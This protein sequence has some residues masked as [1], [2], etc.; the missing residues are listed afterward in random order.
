MNPTRYLGR[1]GGYTEITEMQEMKESDREM[2]TDDYKSRPNLFYETSEEYVQGIPDMEL[3][4]S[5]TFVRSN[6][7]PAAFYY[8]AG[9]SLALI[10]TFSFESLQR[11]FSRKGG[12]LFEVIPSG[13][14]P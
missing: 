12:A 3:V 13:S 2:T 1:R 7:V 4:R 9:I 6:T 11:K 14:M 5:Y 8:V 10:V